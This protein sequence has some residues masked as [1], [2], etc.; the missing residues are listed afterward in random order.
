M[1]FLFTTVTLG[2]DPSYSQERFYQRVLGVDHD[3]VE[4]QFR[5]AEERGIR[6]RKKEAD[7]QVREEPWLFIS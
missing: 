3:R 7:L 2:V 6:V 1:D 4:R 5:K